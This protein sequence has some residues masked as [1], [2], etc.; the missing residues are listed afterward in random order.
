[1]ECYVSVWALYSCVPRALRTLTTFSST[2]EIYVFVFAFR[3]QFHLKREYKRAI[4]KCRGE[5]Q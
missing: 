3:N 2:T 5:T 4:G 1:M